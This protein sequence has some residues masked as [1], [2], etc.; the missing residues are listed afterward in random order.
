[1]GLS[2]VVA[3][4]R[5]REESPKETSASTAI[6]PRNP[7]FSS[8]GR[9]PRSKRGSMVLQERD[10]NA[11]SDTQSIGSRQSHKSFMSNISIG[12]I[13]SA[14]SR[15]SVCSVKSITSQRSRKSLKSLA[16]WKSSRSFQSLGT[17]DSSGSR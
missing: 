15:R 13:K 16:S 3:R 6:P 17:Y 8:S 5:Q 9:K 1:M 10:A 4:S 2:C 11:R 14:I 7:I 12:S